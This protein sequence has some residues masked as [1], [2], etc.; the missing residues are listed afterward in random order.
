MI[1]LHRSD[2]MP[3][4]RWSAH[5]AAAV[6]LLPLA[7]LGWGALAFG[8]VYPVGVLA[9]RGA[10]G[11]RRRASPWP[12]APNTRVDGTTR[13]LKLALFGIGAAIALQIVPVPNA[14]VR[15]VS[16]QTG[17]LVTRLSPA[18]AAGLQ[19]LHPSRSGHETRGPRSH[20]SPR[21]RFCASAQRLCSPL[22]AA[23]ASWSS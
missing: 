7:A 13:A 5:S 18:F 9:A 15:A 2:A 11:R 17:P 20:C 16:P 10:F 4:S 22:P 12:V 19:P 3:T 21:S 23:A 6:Q 14:L 1:A 8:A